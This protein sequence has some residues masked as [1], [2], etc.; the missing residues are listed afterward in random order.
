[1][2]DATY[3]QLLVQNLREARARDYAQIHNLAQRQSTLVGLMMSREEADMMVSGSPEKWTLL[4]KTSG[5]TTRRNPKDPLS[6]DRD[7]GAVK[8]Q[9]ALRIFATP[10]PMVE[11]EHDMAEVD[12]NRFASLVDS[13]FASQGTDHINTIDDDLLA[14]PDSAMENVND[15]SAPMHSLPTLLCPDANGLPSGFTTMMGVNPSNVPNG[16]WRPVVKTYADAFD[17]DAGAVEALC[18]AFDEIKFDKI[19]KNAARLQQRETTPSEC[20]IITGYKGKSL[21]RRYNARNNDQHGL[22]LA[23]DGSTIRGIPLICIS[24]LDT[25]L[26]DYRTSY[27]TAYP[28]DE[29]V[30]YLPNFKDIHLIGH[31]K[32]FFRH[33]TKDMGARQY[34]VDVDI[35][36]SWVNVRAR[37]RDTSAV[38]CPAA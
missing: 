15:Q 21:I 4:T 1:M 12:E 3:S 38:V 8:A 25:K 32:H 29:P 31:R 23:K 16:K 6:I 28:D 2:P 11:W 34:D 36:E 5:N 30:F 24:S 14:V 10:L 9:V 33:V 7:H 37:R 19:A 35:L 13:E 22:E 20:G 18:A 17:V 27:T 26:L